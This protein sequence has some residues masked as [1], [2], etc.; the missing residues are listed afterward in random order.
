MLD[1]RSIDSTKLEPQ[2]RE[3]VDT[4]LSGLTW[5]YDV[6]YGYR[7]LA[8]Q[9]GLYAK[10][11]AGGPK[12]APPGKSAHNYGLAVDVAVRR[13]PAPVGLGV[14]DWT[15]TSAGWVA[16]LDA[17]NAHPRLHSGV[18]FGD[19]D[20]IERLNWRSYRSWAS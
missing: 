8:E 9:G 1:W 14:Y 4:L 3:D 6:I 2:F 18:G 12:A 13:D 10:Y 19:T 15:G 16:M 5:N 17:V 7:S 20:H 11:L